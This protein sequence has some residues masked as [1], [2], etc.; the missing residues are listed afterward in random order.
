M[1][2]LPANV[3]P[4]QRTPEFN[5]ATIPAGLLRDHRTKPGVWAVIHVLEG[6]LDYLIT[7]PKA[8]RHVLTPQHPGIVEPAM[9]HAVHAA[10]AVRFYVEF[11]A[12]PAAEQAAPEATT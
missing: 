7:E 2:T 4:Y 3:R 1:K 9:R 12:V 5:A 10:G 6:T 8:E 11:H